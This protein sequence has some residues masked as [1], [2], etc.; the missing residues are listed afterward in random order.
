MAGIV[1]TLKAKI[2]KNDEE[3]EVKESE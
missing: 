3:R 2:K 1:D